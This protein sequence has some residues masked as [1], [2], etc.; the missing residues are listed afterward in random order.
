VADIQNPNP[1]SYPYGQ[2]KQLPSADGVRPLP[3]TFI[4]PR[5]KAYADFKARDKIRIRG[6]D[7][8][9][10]AKL[11]QPR[12]IDSKDATPLKNSEAV[13]EDVLKRRSHAGMALY[14]EN[15]LVG[16]RLDSIHREIQP[17]WAPDKAILV[18]GLPFEVQQEQNANERGGTYVRQLKFDLARASCETE[19]SIAPE[20]GDIVRIP[21]LFD[22]TGDDSGGYFD[23][24]KVDEDETRFGSTGFFVCYRLS[25]FRSSRY[26]AERK[27]S[28][29]KTTTEQDL[30]ERST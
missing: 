11:D 25:L 4:G 29:E 30:Q 9:Y 10:Y 8:F 28:P 14:G 22:T 17:D 18:R 23:V 2:F 3:D 5:D 7:A 15:A 16:E 12:R 19:W 21:K 6:V 13:A 26:P 1:P 20:P 27:L 24:L